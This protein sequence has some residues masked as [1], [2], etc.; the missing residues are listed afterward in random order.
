MKSSDPPQ[1][2]L[3]IGFLAG[4]QFV[5]VDE[6]GGQQL[7]H[8][9]QVPLDYSRLHETPSQCHVL[10][11]RHRSSPL[12]NPTFLQPV[13]NHVH[14]ATRRGYA[15][16]PEAYSPNLVERLYEKWSSEGISLL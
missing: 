4:K 6:V 12:A 16:Q 14:D 1:V 11:C 10:L 13:G 9:V 2:I 15:H 7:G 8:G 3:A 5:T